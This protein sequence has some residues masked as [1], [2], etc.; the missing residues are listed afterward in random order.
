[1]VNRGTNWEL[2]DLETDPSQTKNLSVEHPDILKE[3]SDSYMA[4]FEK[5][6]VKGFKILPIPVGHKKSPVVELPAHEAVL[7]PEMGKGITYSR[8]PGY[9]YDWI[10]EWTSL[11]ACPVWDIDVVESGDYNI[12]LVYCCSLEDLGAEL[13]IQA[14]N[15]KLRIQVDKPYT[16]KTII[17]PDRSPPRSVYIKKDGWGKLDLGT[18]RLTKGQCQL[19]I[20]AL[21]KPGSQVVE[22]RELVI[23]K[24]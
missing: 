16:S 1:M 23:T 12:T 20:K 7:L 22:F 11:E 19:V 3:L 9:D 21:S 24:L 15:A 5:V 4:W 8:L 10:T 18:I 14:G 13:L 6:S 17:R 2:Y